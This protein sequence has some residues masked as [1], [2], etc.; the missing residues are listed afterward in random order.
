[1]CSSIAV[2]NIAVELHAS[3][4]LHGDLYPRNFVREPDTDRIYAVDF[5][6][7]I[8]GH[9]CAQEKCEELRDLRQRLELVDT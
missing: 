9:H 2:Y 6:H 8:V 7:S 1:V 4:V 5:G 3:G